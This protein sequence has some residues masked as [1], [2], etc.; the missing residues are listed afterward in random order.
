MWLGE[1][2][3]KKKKKKKSPLDQD[4]GPDFDPM[5]RMGIVA[6]VVLQN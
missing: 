2:G 4:L 5:L 3:G 6:V 1:Q